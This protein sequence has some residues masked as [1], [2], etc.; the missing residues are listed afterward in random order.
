MAIEDQKYGLML[1]DILGRVIGAN[2]G[3][4]TESEWYAEG[5]A[6][7]FYDHAFF[8]L[9]ISRGATSLALPSGTIAISGVSSLD[10]LL[11]AAFEAF[12][13]FHYVFSIPETLEDKNFK[14]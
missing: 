7:K 9:K 3:T 5:L 13:T 11:R 6:N 14:Y 8:V 12:L 2:K 10:V 1:L 4:A